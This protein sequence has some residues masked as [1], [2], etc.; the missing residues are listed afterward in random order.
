MTQQLN[1]HILSNGNLVLEFEQT[2][3]KISTRQKSLE[4]K[5]HEFYRDDHLAALFYLGTCDT[6]IPLSPSLEFWRGFSR[7]YIEQIRLNPDIERLR[8]KLSIAVDDAYLSEMIEQTPFMQGAEYI[9]PDFLEACWKKLHGFFQTQIK[10]FKGNVA[11]Y[12]HQYAPDIH[13]LGKIYFHLVENKD[14]EDYPFAFMATYAHGVNKRGES[15]HKPLKYALVEYENE[16]KKMLELLSTV[17]YAGRH[18]ALIAGL[19]DSGELFYPLKWTAGEAFNFLKEIEIYEEAGVLCRVPDWWKRKGNKVRLNITVGDKKPSLIGMESLVDFKAGLV[20]EDTPLTL[21]EAKKLLSQTE[22]LAYLKGKWVALDKERLKQT[23]A[24]LEQA[25]KLMKQQG[26]TLSDALRMLM[27]IQHSGKLEDVFEDELE[28]SCGQWLKSMLE[29]MRDP[30]L[31]RSV[32][33]AKDFKGKLRPYQQK[34]LDWLFLMHS[35]GFGACLADDMGLGKTV[36]VLAFIHTLTKN[37]HGQPANLLILPASLLANWALEI[38]RFTPALRFMTAHPSMEDAKTLKQLDDKQLDDFDLVI[39][40]YG[41]AKRYE[42][43]KSYQWHYIILDEAQA[44]KNPNAGQTKAVKKLKG[45]NRLILTGTPVENHLTDLWSLFDFLNPGLLGNIA[46]FSKLCKGLNKKAGNYSHLRNVIGPYIL[47]RLKT[48]KRVITDLPDKVEVD[49]YA[50]LSKKQLVLYQE[51]VDGLK[52]ALENA[53]GIQRKGLVLASLM[54]FKQICNHPDQY[55]GQHLFNE[56]DSGKFQRLREICETI[57]EKREKLLVFTQFKEMTAPLHG[58]LETVFGRQGL[59]LHG[60]TAVKKRKGLVEKFQGDEYIPYFILSIKAGGVGLNLTA[61]NHVVHFDRWWNPAVE[62]Q[63]TDRAFRIGQH[64]NVM[65]HKFITRGTVE[66]KI[67][68]MLEEKK[69]LSE[70]IIGKT[71]EQLI[72]EMNNEELIN[73]FKINTASL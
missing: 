53:Q 43:I 61:A 11:E 4:K 1:A 55:L 57:L 63:A 54:K 19:L 67:A 50:Y 7:G 17:N 58:F 2:R 52:H 49:S 71:G 16:Q 14:N 41:L 70:D 22:G 28:V 47:R 45:L 27:S 20:L 24:S 46:E 25:R 48:D 35:L 44:I 12:F 21:T 34:G 6:D 31:I 72:T 59:V 39:T 32:S 10:S 42:W 15:Q 66:E 51:L 62:N 8:E 65:V 73:L 13:L 9:T 38:K 36:Q 69:Q 23:I 30:E 5:I 3:E 60:G 40:T 18:S 33:L 26:V 56:K 68:K 64:K 37:K 29:K